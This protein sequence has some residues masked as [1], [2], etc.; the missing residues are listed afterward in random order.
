MSRIALLAV[1]AAAGSASAQPVAY[2]ID[3]N[4][5]D[6]LFRINLNTGMATD[7]G[8]VNFGDAEGLSFGPGGAIYAIGG[9]VR[10]FWRITPPPGVLVGPTGAQGGLDAGLAFH[11]G[12]MY[13][14]SGASSVSTELY[15]VNVGVGSTALVGTGSFF[16]DNIAIHPTTGEAY[17]ID[18]IF[19]DSLYRINLA[20][21]AGALVGP[22][23]IGPVS[24]QVGSSFDS[25][26]TLWALFSSGQM[27]TVNRVTGQATLR[28]Q[29]MGAAGPLSGFEGLAIEL[30]GPCYPDCDGNGTLNVN[31]YICFQTKFALGC[32]PA[33]SFVNGGF[34][35]GTF[36]GW[37]IAGTA[38]GQSPVQ[39][40]EP[41]DI[42][43]P[44]P[45]GVSNAGKFSV[46]QI[47]PTPGVQEGIE[48]RQ[49]VNLTA[50]VP[51]MIEFDAAAVRTTSTTNA[52][53]GVFSLI[54]NGA[55]QAQVASGSTNNTTPHYHHLMANFVP[56]ASGPHA[57]GA[58]ITRPYTIPGVGG[59]ET[60]FQY[61]DNFNIGGGG[62][63]PC[64]PDCDGNGV[65]NV[66]DY[67]CFQTKFALG[68]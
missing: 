52:E 34:A 68:C 58:R 41:F 26:G 48:I 36:A 29:V 12:T 55:V 45:L 46:G 18:A 10:E 4:G 8:P 42:D 62:G 2:S 61:V 59:S 30:G 24:E 9:T 17:G 23:N 47:A 43:G 21:G 64:Y 27:Y 22:L 51:Y 3:S 20:N 57:I 40:V 14:V 1:L 56:A 11:N 15:T 32:Q 60:L 5:T 37:T 6:H 33:A 38:N 19:Q 7:L 44:G 67:I 65:L 49:M 25:S 39:L 54:V 53:G 50:G 13:N 66:N 28:F 35:S 16:A 31:D 63:G